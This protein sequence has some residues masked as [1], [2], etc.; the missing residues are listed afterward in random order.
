[1]VTLL[2]S[3]R[4]AFTLIELL[5]VIAIIA[6]L[7]GLLLPA[8]QKV[9]EA[10]AR[11]TC[12][13]NLK[14]IGLALQNYHDTTKYL[15]PGAK[16]DDPSF[17]PGPIIFGNSPNPNGDGSCWLVFILP[18]I[19]QGTLYSQFTFQG[20]SGWAPGGDNTNPKCSS[21]INSRASDNVLISTYRCPSSPLT[22][23]VNCRSRQGLNE[24]HFITRSS[25]MG[26]SGAKDDIDGSGQF[27]EKR[28]TQGFNAGFVA[29]GGVLTT[30][31]QKLKLGNIRDG[32]SNTL[33][34]SEDSDYI[35][36]NA[37]PT[38]V[39]HEEWGATQCGFLSGG[40]SVNPGDDGR[41]FNLTT[42]RYNINQTTGWPTG[43]TSST[44]VGGNGN[45][46]SGVDGNGANTPLNSAHSG[47]VNGLFCDGSVRFL[48]NNTSL[49]NLARMATRDDRGVVN[50]D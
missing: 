3:R 10:A 38:P 40:A 31:F 15:P 1:M 14:Q 5:V 27:S 47:G 19:E 7:I 13:N 16:K 4:S 2:R 29:W 43:S 28:Y 41:G 6:I 42:I 30:G 9:R 33:A 46:Q 49:L 11:A 21:L 37:T 34:V 32:T 48:R 45:I 39:Q 20:D 36:D 12:T 44:G 25:Y 22:A 18:Y 23:L 26:I 24:D 35:Y 8:I 17:V 50:F